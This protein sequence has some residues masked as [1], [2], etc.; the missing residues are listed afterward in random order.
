MAKVTSMAVQEKQWQAQDDAHAL[1]RAE[2]IKNDPGRVKMAAA[3][4]KKMQQESQ[5]RADAMKKVAQK[6]PVTK[7]VQ[8][9][10]QSQ[11]SGKKK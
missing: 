6:A 1:A 3:A 5:Q 2:E 7:S 10:V 8:K 11:S 4:A 9:R